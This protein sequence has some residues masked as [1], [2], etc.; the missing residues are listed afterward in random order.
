MAADIEGKMR[1]TP[2]EELKLT[3][4]YTVP[5]CE[6]RAWEESRVKVKSGTRVSSQLSLGLNTSLGSFE[7]SL[8]ISQPLSED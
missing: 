5:C 1:A 3:P 7:T 6:D 8:R 2:A 4:K